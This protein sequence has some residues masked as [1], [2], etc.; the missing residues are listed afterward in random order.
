MWGD[1]TLLADFQIEVY[2]HKAALH[3]KSLHPREQ[4]LHDVVAGMGI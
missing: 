3:L 4:L 2:I 1:T